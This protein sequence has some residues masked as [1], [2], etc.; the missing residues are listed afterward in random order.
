MSCNELRLNN[1]V[2]FEITVT[3]P[4][5]DPPYVNDATVTVKVLD[6][7]GVEV[8]PSTVLSYVVG[9]NGIYR[10]T[11]DPIVGLVAGVIYTV[12]YD[13]TG[14]DSLKGQFKEKIKAEDC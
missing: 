5:I 3:N 9:S 6:P 4:L 2:N 8:L 11:V 13:I 10:E 12:V 1:S 7:D 14:S